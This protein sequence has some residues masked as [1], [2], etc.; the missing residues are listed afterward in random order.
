[1]MRLLW[2]KEVPATDKSARKILD[3]E[4]EL[5]EVVSSEDSPGG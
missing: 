4:I 3:L 2:G 5:F 1:M